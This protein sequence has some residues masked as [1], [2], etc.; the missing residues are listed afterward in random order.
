MKKIRVLFVC[1]G[2]I[3]RSPTAEGIFAHLV[4]ERGHANYIETD[5]AGILDEHVGQEPDSRTLRTAKKR[6]YDFSHLRARQVCKTDFAEF[7]YIIAMDR[8]HVRM[9]NMAKP[10]D[11][12]G[13]IQL[14]CD[15]VPHRKE[16]EVEDPYY[17][18]QEGF[19][20]VFDLCYEAS[21]ALLAAILTEHFPKNAAR[22]H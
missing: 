19:D 11:P 1:T 21:E 16:R 17:G 22:T 4:R 15:F 12:R 7:D 3:C 6:G 10:K 8:G 18:G 14:F 20:H 9:L 2:N 13:R 5:S